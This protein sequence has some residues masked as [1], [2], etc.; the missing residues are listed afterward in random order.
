MG[1]R[2]MWMPCSNMAHVLHTLYIFRFRPTAHAAPGQ[3]RRLEL[4]L[5]YRRTMMDNER[6]AAHL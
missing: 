1:F 6:L 5:Y 2:S 4:T 3:R